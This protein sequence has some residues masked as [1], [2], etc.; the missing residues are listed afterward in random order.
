MPA[1]AACSRGAG[2]VSSRS[3]QPDAM[4]SRNRSEPGVVER[5]VV[6]RGAGAAAT[7]S[8][9]AVVVCSTAIRADNPEVEE[10]A[11]RRLPRVRR[12]EMLAELMRMQNTVAVAGT[13]GKT[14]TTS[15]VAAILDAGGLERS[16]E[17]RVGK[18][19]SAVCRSR[20]SPYH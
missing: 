15:M 19:C 11:R 10:A 4:K 5:F 1:K 13:H 16:E 14:T 17:R 9:A 3:A 7:V 6:A 20:W 2:R 8:G 12:A 18:E